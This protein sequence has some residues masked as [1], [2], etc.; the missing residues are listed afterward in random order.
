MKFTI[1]LPETLQILFNLYILF[2]LIK[3]DINYSKI[4]KNIVKINGKITILQDKQLTKEIVQE[5][6][7][8]IAKK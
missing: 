4:N 5:V 6:S 8:E 7:K 2:L 1:T 3:N